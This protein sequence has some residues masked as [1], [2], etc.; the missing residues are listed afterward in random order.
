MVPSCDSNIK[1]AEVRGLPKDRG[2]PGLHS[3]TL[4]QTKLQKGEG[5]AGGGGGGRDM[6]TPITTERTEN[7]IVLTPEFRHQK[8]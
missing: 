4:F 6:M 1:D 2:Q 3:E 7:Y 5:G 8:I